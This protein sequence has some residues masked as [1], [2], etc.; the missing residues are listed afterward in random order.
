MKILFKIVIAWKNDN[1][2]KVYYKKDNKSLM[3]EEFVE[4]VYAIYRRIGGRFMV[5]YAI[6]EKFSVILI[7][8]SA[9]TKDY[10][11]E[12]LKLKKLDF[13]DIKAVI[14][15]HGHPEH[16]S[17][18]HKFAK[19]GVPVYVPESEVFDDPK[20]FPEIY[21]FYEKMP[22]PLK[23]KKN[24]T[25]GM[26]IKIGD[27]VLAIYYCG[28]H[29]FDHFFAVHT[30]SGILF[31]G[32]MLLEFP[33]SPYKFLI[34]K[35][36]DPEQRKKFFEAIVNLSLSGIAPAHG[37][38]V[39]KN[40][41]EVVRDAYNAQKSLQNEILY[42]LEKE[43]EVTPREID[44]ELRR[45]IDYI[46]SPE[47]RTKYNYLTIEAFLRSFETKGLVEKQGKKWIYKG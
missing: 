37:M 26:K 32:S 6:I 18:A 41:L 28:G 45:R 15:T 40:W 12:F 20:K 10:I 34:D 3:Y 42:V 13:K 44:E 4:G 1:Y 14:V 36:G 5:T 30:K 22:K 19:K 39:L 46:W 21:G 24:L 17:Y 35:S 43:K 16:W 29:S 9:Y 31:C 2:G 25:H 47:E 38:P 23:E 7:D 8:P 33:E 11:D 27:G